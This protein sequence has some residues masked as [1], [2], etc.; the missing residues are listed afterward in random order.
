MILLVAQER[1]ELAILP[2]PP[3][4]LGVQVFAPQQAILDILMLI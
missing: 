4:V 3:P 1:L 2:Q